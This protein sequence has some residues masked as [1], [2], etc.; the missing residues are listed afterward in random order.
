MMSASKHNV[1]GHP[2]FV[3]DYRLTKHRAR[4]DKMPVGTINL[5]RLASHVELTP[6]FRKR[7]LVAALGHV[8]ANNCETNAA[9]FAV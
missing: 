8:P 5:L 1:S 9:L 3:E 7:R 6:S 4:A 2:G